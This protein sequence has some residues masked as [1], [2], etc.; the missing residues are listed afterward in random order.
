MGFIIFSKKK[1][2]LFSLV[3]FVIMSCPLLNSDIPIDEGCPYY[4]VLGQSIASGEGYKDIYYPG[5]PPN[6]SY[7]IFFYPLL[8]S[9]IL[10]VFPNTI[11]GLKLLSLLLGIGS[12]AVIYLFFSDK[13]N[14]DIQ[15]SAKSLISDLK[16]GVWNNSILLHPLLLLLLLSINLWFLSF[17][18][19]IM[20]E[21][22]YIFF[23]LLTLLF[24]EK[25]GKQQ[26]FFNK[27][28]FI[29]L[30]S[31]TITFFIKPMALSINIAV[32][33]FFMLKRK[34]KEG[35]FFAGFCFLLILP[36]FYRNIVIS[37]VGVSSS[38]LVRFI[39]GHQLNI[40]GFAKGI[41]KNI[42]NYWQ[43]ISIAIFP[44]G[45]LN[46]SLFY[47]TPVSVY[48][49]NGLINK[50]ISVSFP[51][52]QGV[53]DIINLFFSLTVLFGFLSQ[54]KK[55]RLIEIYVLSY[56]FIL[57]LFS[58]MFSFY[59]GARCFFC[60]LPF[61]WYYFLIGFFVFLEKSHISR[62]SSNRLSLGVILIIFAGNIIPAIGL[63]KE[64][65]KYMLNYKHLSNKER[66]DYHEFQY[67]D[68]F[69]AADWIKKNVLPDAVVMHYNPGAFYL[70]SNR[71]TVFFD[72][73]SNKGKNLERIKSMV[74]NKNV[75][76]II[77][78]TEQEEKI[79]FELNY[80]WKDRIFIPFVE[81]R[82]GM[83]DNSIRIYKVVKIKPLA[84]VKNMEGVFFFNRGKYDIAIQKFKKVLE[85]ESNF[86][87]Y[88]NLAN[89]YEKKG[90]IKEAK[91]MFRKVIEFEPSYERCRNVFNIISQREVVKQCPNDVL[92]L[93]KLGEHYLKNHNN[94]L[95]MET[96][97][98]VLKL[99]TNSA[100]VYYMFGITYINTNGD[101]GEYFWAIE[102]F[103]KAMNLDP[104]LKYKAKHYIELACKKQKEKM[105]YALKNKVLL[106]DAAEF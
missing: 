81:F 66:K 52:P 51:F 78:K 32:L 30:F 79:V 22:A 27:S 75:N 12:L 19:L 2:L 14:K 21:T 68:Y 33:I 95:A 92:A 85:L 31:M 56:L 61:I 89:S 42:S 65:V 83:E 10:I 8:L 28:L 82:G 37:E 70:W 17:S 100:A 3:L 54:I 36:W 67:A 102:K 49:F 29:A 1:Y 50:P 40:V 77:T 98:E 53:I 48:F 34:Y 39:S 60:L 44:A 69:Q 20:P 88:Y 11:I 55:K 41:I 80:Q 94:M 87:G 73:Y 64:N 99:N 105:A 74:N 45:S 101:E 35:F 93:E 18:V 62:M 63:I 72:I 47:E 106:K 26:D 97:M 46:N 9:L 25:Y 57:V 103:K 58:P 6:T 5:N 86:V 15:K 43:M 59:S 91:K 7:S 104:G 76:Y 96:F 23:S 38:C 4:L 71:K 24:L 13:Y 90:L 84:K 16:K